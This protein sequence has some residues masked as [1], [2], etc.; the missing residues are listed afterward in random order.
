MEMDKRKSSE[1]VLPRQRSPRGKQ[2]KGV[3]SGARQEDDG[4]KPYRRQRTLENKP[5]YC[6]RIDVPF[7][8]RR[9][10]VRQ[11]NE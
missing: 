3:H 5:S 10:S 11:N 6:T 2:W 7:E 9:E 1:T 8:G 4:N